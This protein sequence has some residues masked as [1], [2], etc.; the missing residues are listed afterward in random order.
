M[1]PGGR[2]TSLHTLGLVKDLRPLLGEDA[3]YYQEAVLAP[4]AGGFLAELPN[5]MTSSH[6]LYINVPL[7]ESLGLEVPETY[8]DMVAMVP[9]LKDNNLDVILMGAQDDWVIQ[10]TL[11]SMIVGRLLG[12]QYVDDILAGK[13]KFTDEPF[14]KAL[15]F[16]KSLFD[17]GVLSTR[18]LQTPYN[19]VNALWAAGQA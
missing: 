1:W 8:E 18:I 2:S 7:L 6:A 13:A 4:Q 11:F 12:D 5:T 16:Y 15:E 17:D 10:S 3:K 9:V 19:D 14:V